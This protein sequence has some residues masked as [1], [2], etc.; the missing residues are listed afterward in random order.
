MDDMANTDP[1]LLLPT[2]GEPFWFG[3]VTKRAEWKA[4]IHLFVE[5]WRRTGT[6]ADI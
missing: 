3:W 6:F 4:G 5:V 2:T 1:V